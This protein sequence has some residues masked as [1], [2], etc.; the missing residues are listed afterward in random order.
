MR[1]S[2]IRFSD[3]TNT[4]SSG[5]WTSMMG[6]A[7]AG[8]TMWYSLLNRTGCEILLRRN[9]R[10]SSVA[11]QQREKENRWSGRSAFGANILEASTLI[12]SN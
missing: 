11:M 5:I 8:G 9:R 1:I 4:A 2:P 6:T 3:F 7:D 10:N 12:S